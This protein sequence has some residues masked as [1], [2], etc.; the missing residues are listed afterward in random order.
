M[1]TT[2]SNALPEQQQAQTATAQPEKKKSFMDKL[3]DFGNAGAKNFLAPGA[4][5]TGVQSLFN[6]GT[7]I[8]EGGSYAAAK[9][10]GNEQMANQI[11]QKPLSESS[12]IAAEKGT[13]AGL[14]DVLG[15]TAEVGLAAAP[16][17]KAGILANVAS[18]AKALKPVTAIANK[19]PTLA[20]YARYAGQ[21]ALY[22]GGFSTAKALQEN[23][24]S[25]K[26]FSEAI[27]GAT[28]GA[29]LSVAIPAVVEGTVRAVKNIASLYSGASTGAI[30][31]AFNN[32]SEVSKTVREYAKDETKK[33]QLVD[34]IQKSF[35]NIKKAR[36]ASYESKL[37]ALNTDP[38][39]NQS[40]KY[41]TVLQLQN[42]NPEAAKIVEALNLD[43]VPVNKLAE[44]SRKAILDAGIAPDKFLNESLT[45]WQKSSQQI[46]KE[47]AKNKINPAS[48]TGAV[49]DVLSQYN[50]Q[51]IQQDIKKPVELSFTKSPFTRT[52]QGQVQELYSR[53]Q[54][55]DDYTPT[56]VNDLKK[57]VNS[58][59][60]KMGGGQYNAFV[61]TMKNKVNEILTG[62]SD[63]IAKMNAQYQKESQFIDRIK[64]E[65]LGSDKMSQTTR[66]NRVLKIFDKNSTVRKEV[67]KEMGAISGQDFL[68]EVAG[69]ALSGWLPQGWVQRFIIGG[70]GASGVIASKV[71]PLLMG[72]LLASPRIV[73]KG[74]RVLGTL[75]QVANPLKPYA[76]P[77][78]MKTLNQKK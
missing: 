44:T 55:W 22:G 17:A 31:R 76:I 49:D 4:K 68:N 32:P 47:I 70:A 5:L 30:E 42:R 26:L 58:Y 62:S 52:Q 71:G 77:A 3:V 19:F 73:G 2:P 6:L 65:L 41:N 74:A 72:G 50:I 78:L 8:G 25:K 10:T 69:E 75:N 21:G 33:V 11:L 39:V 61:D 16:F 48:I 1:P 13:G 37:A 57:V 59:R 43:D 27:N 40:F 24:D 38:K 15:K 67:I 18:G 29:I 66:I 12:K 51:T 35:E 54:N 14:K 56:G 23:A 20:R 64:K 45:N 60:D 28:T 53:I 7:T 9:V 34:D 36:G 46:F 63:D